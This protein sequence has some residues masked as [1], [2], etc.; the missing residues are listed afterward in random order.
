MLAE[1][2]A[3]M[4]PVQLALDFVQLDC[5]PCAVGA[6]NLGAQVA[7]QRLDLAPVKVAAG[8]FGEDRFQ[9]ALVLVT[10]RCTGGSRIKTESGASLPNNSERTDDRSQWR[11]TRLGHKPSFYL[12]S[13]DRWLSPKAVVRSGSW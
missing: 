1:S 9:N 12:K 10:H 6:L 2:A 11:M 3:V 13:L 4:R 5:E 7:Q 8:R